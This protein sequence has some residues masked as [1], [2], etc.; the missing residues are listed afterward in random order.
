MILITTQHT[1]RELN[2]DVN[3][4]SQIINRSLS[5]TEFN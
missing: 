5:G 4:W 2:F 3:N 1:I